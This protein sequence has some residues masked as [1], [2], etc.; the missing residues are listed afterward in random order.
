MIYGSYDIY[1][2]NTLKS[3]FSP[4]YGGT[5]NILVP[6]IVLNKSRT[7][8]NSPWA[9]SSPKNLWYSPGIYYC[10]D[11]VI[12]QSRRQ[13]SPRNSAIPDFSRPLR[14]LAFNLS[15]LKC[16]LVNL[17][18]SKKLVGSFTC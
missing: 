14:M 6:G 5:E 12:E 7:I 13:I 18:S 2:F 1:A 9:F 8:L 3:G 15:R 17:K 16:S 4:D 11:L 10:L